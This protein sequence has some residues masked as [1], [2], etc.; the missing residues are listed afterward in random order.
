M[1]HAH[2]QPARRLRELDQQAPNVRRARETDDPVTAQVGWGVGDRH[3]LRTADLDQA[4]KQT[5]D[6]GLIA[7]LPTAEH[8]A[9]DE[10]KRRISRR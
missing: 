9:I 10:S 7:G 6:V 2:A 3:S 5:R 1:E 4:L 8:V